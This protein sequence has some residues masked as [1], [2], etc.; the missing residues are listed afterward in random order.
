M[1]S[2]KIPAIPDSDDDSNIEEA[3]E[4][5]FA[6]GSD[7]Q[8]VG[9]L[10]NS[11][12][13]MENR[14]KLG[15]T[16]LE[17][18]FAK[19]NALQNHQQLAVYFAESNKIGINQPFALAQYVDFKNPTTYMMYTWQAGLGLPDREYYFTEDERSEEIRT[20]YV[21]HMQKM[22]ELAGVTGAESAVKTI[23]ALETRMANE[24]MLKEKTRDRVRGRGARRQRQLARERLRRK[25]S[26]ERPPRRRET[27]PEQVWG[28]LDELLEYLQPPASRGG[29]E[30]QELKT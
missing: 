29:E 24:H 1:V 14:N 30:T 2:A 6:V 16:P 10:Y 3:A 26:A 12:M 18:E 28:E 9:A 5:D 13:D 15:I 23:M 4:G 20:A 19:I 25:E 22:L 21:T 11:Y 17:A 7:E 8:K 27:L